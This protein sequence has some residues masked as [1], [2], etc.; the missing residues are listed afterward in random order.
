VTYLGEKPQPPEGW[1]A[2]GARLPR[3]YVTE[4]TSPGDLERTKGFPLSCVTF[5]TL[6]LRGYLVISV[7]YGLPLPRE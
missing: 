6:K 4:K 2:E 5:Q 3:R 1:N 7:W